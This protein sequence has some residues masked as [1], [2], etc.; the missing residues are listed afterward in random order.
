MKEYLVNLD[1][2]V[3]KEGLALDGYTVKADS[4]ADVEAKV[5]NHLKSVG[6]L[7]ASGI[8]MEHLKDLGVI[9]G[10]EIIK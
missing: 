6:F 8:R 7:K 9:T 5:Y 4:Y 1:G 10:I 2:Y 3:I